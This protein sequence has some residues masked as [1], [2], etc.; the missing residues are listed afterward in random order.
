MRTRMLNAQRAALLNEVGPASN[1]NTFRAAEVPYTEPPD[2]RVAK[3][4]QPLA[5]DELKPG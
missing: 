5:L 2:L 1:V 3:P 4:G